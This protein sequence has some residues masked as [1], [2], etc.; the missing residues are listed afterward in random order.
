MT[1]NKNYTKVTYQD[2]LE[3]F[4][5]RLQNDDR[6]KNL[7]SASIYYLFM[8]MLASTFDMTNFYMQR[9]AE[10]G[11][12]DTAR[13]DSSVIK[14]GK[15]LG[16]NPIRNTPAEAEIQIVIKGPLPQSI[17]PGAVIYFSQEETDLVFDNN[18]FILNTD[19]SYTLTENDIREGQSATWSKTLTFSTPVDTMKYYIIQDV[20]VYNNAS[21]EP[22]K[23]FQGEVKTHIIR[24]VSNFTKLGKSYQFYDIDDLKFSNW[25]GHR[26][27]Y[28]W[29]KDTF[30]KNNSWT[31][32]GIGKTED[33]ALSQNNL[34]DIEDC[35]IYLNER[36][37]YGDKDTSDAAL[38][39]C[40]LTTNG[41]KTVRLKFG[42][43]VSTVCG[44]VSQD[45]NIYVKYLA[46]EGAK[47]NRIGSRTA[48]IK[49]NNKFY[50]SYS[51][52]VIDITNNIKFVLNTDIIGGT[53]FENQQSIKNNAPLYFA[54][55]NRLV[56]K[57]DFIS[58]FKGL[59]TPLNVKNAIAWSQDEIED[60]SS[61]GNTTYKY[62]QNIICYCIVS[63]LYNTN[64]TVYYPLNVLTDDSTNTT[65]TFS[66]YGTTKDYLSHLSD[67]VKMLY[68]FNSFLSTQ[69]QDN[70][71]AQ[72]L[73]NVKVIRENAE[74]KMI[75][76]SKLFSLPPIV[77]YYDVVGTVTVN[78]LSKMQEY[79]RDVENK[80]YKWLEENCNFN[81]K[82]YKSDI[83]KFFNEREETKSVNLDIRVSDIIKSNFIKYNFKIEKGTLTNIYYKT[84]TDTGTIDQDINQ[85]IQRYTYNT[86]KIPKTDNEGNKLSVSMFE[87]KMLNVYFDGVVWSG[88]NRTKH[89]N[90]SFI[91]SDVIE[92][93][94]NIILI[95]TGESYM[96][97]AL[98]DK[99]NDS[100]KACLHVEV[101]A[102]DDFSSL[103][104]F[105]PSYSAYG[106]SE[107]DITN[108]QKDVYDWV[109]KSNE[110][111]EADRPINLPYFITVDNN[112]T[113][114][115][116]IN[117]RAETYLRKG[118]IQN[119][120]KNQL[121][122]RAFWQYFVPTIIGK[123]YDQDFSDIEIT[124]EV[125][126]NIDSLIYD[127]YTAL[128]VVFADTVLDDNNNIVN[129]SVDSEIPVVRLN[130]TYKYE[131]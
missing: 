127:L 18:K 13:L 41:D 48:E 91:P 54:S 19:Y 43:G 115:A 92:S 117:T 90:I 47:A 75:I 129:Y 118:I 23:I 84:S 96:S 112:I 14:H 113:N 9:T 45:E 38:P 46:C 40:S 124:D 26:D 4:T 29:H 70:P 49:A 86:I 97:S 17:K 20:K 71:S 27:P 80:I 85:H 88:D 107:E 89:A 3:D 110:V 62:I 12:I 81:T 79:K 25:Y 51:G 126:S 120:L 2:L 57:R 6:F 59:S 16:Y 53:D 73:K 82:I 125:W 108:I 8:E 66:I 131:H 28:A 109:I 68:S 22:I 65:G 103:S 122:E 37:I 56:S 111:T 121:T 1:N 95:M 60:F 104:N 15:N 94:S 36:L 11:F 64:G 31:K 67:Y 119:D 106:L 76:G 7:S 114:K 55:N 116:E 98:I 101:A 33:E 72:W 105:P 39:I 24:G 52:G 34:F 30:Y 44:L 32:V 63:T 21:L 42:D 102:T 99:T 10:E 130:I 50:A 58:Y 5:A 35:S 83:I 78:S 123:Y 87:N 74:P 69:Y 128:K 77:Q 100:D 61:G 93:D